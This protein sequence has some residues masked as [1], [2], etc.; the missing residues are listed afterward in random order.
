ME[1]RAFWQKNSASKGMRWE[2]AWRYREQVVVW[3]RLHN[4]AFP[5]Q[6]PG[7]LIFL[8]KTHQSLSNTNLNWVPVLHQI[9][10]NSTSLSF[11]S[12]WKVSSSLANRP[13]S[14]PHTHPTLLSS[15]IPVVC[16]FLLPL[17]LSTCSP[18]WEHPS[19]QY[20]VSMVSPSTAGDNWNLFQH[21]WRVVYQSLE[22]VIPLT[23]FLLLEIYPN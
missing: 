11:L 21:F 20:L 19:W 22:I 18:P 1:S 9:R 10:S 4:T 12:H 2:G 13:F 3:H 14:T 6:N 16:S 8:I 7:A 5:Q 23:I 17:S 15:S